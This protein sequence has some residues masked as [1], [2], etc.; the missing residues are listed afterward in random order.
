MARMNIIG[1]L[2]A[3]KTSLR[4][5]L[6]GGSS[7]DNMDS[8]DGISVHRVKSPFNILDSK[9]GDWDHSKH[10]EA[11]LIEEFQ[12]FVVKKQQEKNKQEE[13][14]M[15]RNEKV[16]EPD[17]APAKKQKL[18]DRSAESRQES[19]K[20]DNAPSISSQSEPEVGKTDEAKVFSDFKRK[21]IERPFEGKSDEDFLTLTIWDFGG[22][23]DFISTHHLFI[24]V[25]A[26][27]V[28]VMD[29]SR[30]LTEELKK[31]VKPGHP[32]TPAKFLHYWLNFIYFQAKRKGVRPN[33]ALVLTHLDKIEEGTKEKKIT[34][35]LNEIKGED[36]S[37]P[38]SKLIT[39]ENTYVVSNTRGKKGDFEKLKQKLLSHLIKQDSFTKE[40]P[41]RWLPLQ[42]AMLSKATNDKKQHLRYFDVKELATKNN[43]AEEELEDFL[44]T[45]HSLGAFLY[46]P[47]RESDDGNI[48]ITDPQ[49]LPD[50]CKTLITTHE[51]LEERK[52]NEM[53]ESIVENLKKGTVTKNDLKE[54]WADDDEVNLIVRVM[55]KFY[56]IAPLDLAGERFVIPCMLPS[57]DEPIDMQDDFLKV[58]EIHGRPQLEQ[59]EK[60]LQGL[61]PSL[62]SRILAELATSSL[63]FSQAN[64]KNLHYN[65]ALL[66]AD[67]GVS[68]LL[69][70]NDWKAEFYTNEKSP[71][72]NK[73]TESAKNVI[74][75]GLQGL[76][77]YTG[78]FLMFSKPR[79]ESVISS[80]FRN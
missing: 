74:E 9:S 75:G 33:V 51:F 56:L 19:P 5:R 45:Y 25:E 12:R 8:T 31:D 71:D 10:N 60:P 37:T 54:L 16:K 18:E 76:D 21:S 68:V 4:H 55:K 2:R 1:H 50:V 23:D 36:K 32:N 38:Y 72:R 27:N 29:I 40:V 63:A 47:N 59:G 73:D 49:W 53:K 66:E 20:D 3:G 69:N 80:E 42:A 78:K 61:F 24:D 52:G 6:M 34:K 30:D 79:F 64:P 15:E 26:T 14:E 17:E 46:Y 43:I 11:S 41:V 48:V 70:R 28:I 57:I 65:S 39:R 35:I 13:M 22:Q 62:L 58:E 67:D 7:V 77:M 44:E